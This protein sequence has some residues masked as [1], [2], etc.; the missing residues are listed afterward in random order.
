MKAEVSNLAYQTE[1]HL[2]SKQRSHNPDK[3]RLAYKRS[4]SFVYVW[5]EMWGS[6]CRCGLCVLRGTNV[7][8]LSVW[9]MRVCEGRMWGFCRCGLCVCARDECGA[10]VGVGYACVRGTNVGLLSVW[11]M[12]VCEGRMSGLLSVW[13]MVCAR[14]ECGASVGVGY[15]CMRGTNVGLLS[16]WV[17]CVC[18]GRMWGLGNVWKLSALSALYVDCCMSF[19]FWQ[20]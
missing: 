9:V 15:V 13:V 18:E 5:G 17:V 11:V 4:V 1:I 10:S 2:K 12:R 6:F 16:V 14:D 19:L 8:H 20:R 7:G 3:S